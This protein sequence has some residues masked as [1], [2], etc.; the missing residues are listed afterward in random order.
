VF[1]IA[2]DCRS[3]LWA[4]GTLI[5][6]LE[7]NMVDMVDMVVDVVAVYN[8]LGEVVRKMALVVVVDNT[9]GA[10]VAAVGQP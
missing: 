4:A 2:S 3:V 9:A 1:E 6:V 7:V 10:L 8:T 5:A